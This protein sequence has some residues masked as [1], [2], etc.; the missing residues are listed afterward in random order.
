MDMA[1]IHVQGD[2]A[3][4]V[5]DQTFP[6][7][8]AGLTR[9][10]YGQWNAAQLRTLWGSMRL[11]RTALL[12]AGAI[13]ASA[14]WYDFEAIVDGDA[15]RTLGIGAVFTPPDLRGRGHARRLVE[16]MLA[17]ARGEG[18]RQAL[19]FS[20]I[21]PGYYESLGFA[22]VPREI[23]DLE[24]IPH[25]RGSPA[26]LVRAG[27]DTDIEHI[28]DMHAPEKVRERW[29]LRRTGDFIR[30]AIAKRRLLAGLGKPGVRQVEF[31]VTEE[32]Y[33]AVAYVLISRGP[34]GAWLLECGDRDPTGARVG[35]MLQSIQART[36]AEAPSRLRAWLPALWWPPQ[37]RIVHTE[38]ATEA[39]MLRSLT[40]EP[41]PHLRAEDVR[42]WQSDV[43]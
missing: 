25:R 19:L 16:E 36:P 43:F 15:C 21:G 11:R 30:F 13:L 6:Q 8:G 4:T 2:A 1:I 29:A 22:V 14:K 24:V 5:L 34:E 9:R 31:Y 33:R 42:Y 10:A 26:V 23:V 28:A 7:W 32:G 38:A 41:L 20:E 37:V 17:L 3:E 40:D 35:A 18:Y 39:M 27:E 12:D